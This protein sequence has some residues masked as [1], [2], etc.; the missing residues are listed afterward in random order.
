MV[1]RR[2]AAMARSISRS[3]FSV[4]FHYTGHL[5][6]SPIQ[7]VV[8]HH[9]ISELPAQSLLF[10]GESKPVL[11]LLGRVAAAF[12]PLPLGLPRRRQDQ[13]GDRFGALLLDLLGAPEVDLEQQI[14]P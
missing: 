5:R 2:S 1:G 14:G 4:A 13:N 8:D 9:M 3:S 10:V 12:E 11:D 7:V 6:D